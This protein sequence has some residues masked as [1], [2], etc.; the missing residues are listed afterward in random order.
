MAELFHEKLGLVMKALSLTRADVA[1]RLRVDKSLVGRWV[2]GKAMPSAHNLSRLTAL[3]AERAG[4][5]SM[6]DWEA[7]LPD[8]ARLVGVEPKLLGQAPRP[9]SIGHGLPGLF[10]SMALE[11]GQTTVRRGPAYEGFFRNTRP[12][13]DIPGRFLHDYLMNRMEDDGLYSYTHCIGK[14]YVE[15]RMICLHSQL[16]I[17]GVEA[18]GGLPMFAIVN[19]VNG[20]KA[21][22]YEGLMLY[23]A[24]DFGNTPFASAF[25]AE[26]IADLSGDRAA[27]EAF[28]AEL[29]PKAG[30]APVGAVPPDLEA[31][32]QREFGPAAHAAGQDMLLCM[33]LAR[34]LSRIAA[35]A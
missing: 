2:T 7:D 9:R 8:V 27:D 28:L 15:A 17:V 12:C 30:L 21:E 35:P 22:T 4:K 10:A 33:P 19:G 26:R 18:L 23:A 5:F 11:G 6:L 20:S 25:V 14:I 32:L 31:H 13:S 24:L 1:V 29:A 16:F 3:V 34:T